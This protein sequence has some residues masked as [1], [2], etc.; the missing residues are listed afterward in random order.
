MKAIQWKRIPIPFANMEAYGARWPHV[1]FVVSFDHANPERGFGASFKRVCC[2]VVF[3]DRS[4]ESLEQ[5]QAAVVTAHERS[6]Q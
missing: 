5:A 4:F 3:L 6:K 1:S 2:D